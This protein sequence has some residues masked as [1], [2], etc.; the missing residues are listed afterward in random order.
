MLAQMKNFFSCLSLFLLCDDS[1]AMEFCKIYSSWPT[2][3]QIFQYLPFTLAVVYPE[4]KKKKPKCI[5]PV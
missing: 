2:E 1:T 5:K 3:K 4:N